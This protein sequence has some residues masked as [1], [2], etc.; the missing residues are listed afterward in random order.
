M[1][2]QIGV[3]QKSLGDLEKCVSRKAPK[4]AKR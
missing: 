2:A 4:V 1:K 3:I